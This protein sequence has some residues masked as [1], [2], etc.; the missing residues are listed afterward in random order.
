ML[1]RVHASKVAPIAG[2]ISK[3]ASVLMLVLKDVTIML[4][5]HATLTGVMAYHTTSIQVQ[6]TKLVS[7]PIGML[8]IKTAYA[9]MLAT[10]DVSRHG[11][12]SL[13]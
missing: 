11:S 8:A 6:A 9:P 5:S 4:A 10:H 7:K 13:C 1:T 12:D 2:M 3:D